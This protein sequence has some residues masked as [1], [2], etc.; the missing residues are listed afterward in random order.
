MDKIELLKEWTKICPYKIQSYQDGTFAELAYDP[1]ATYDDP[2]ECCKQLTA[3][4]I[5][6]RSDEVRGLQTALDAKR[7]KFEFLLSQEKGAK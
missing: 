2:I 5:R 7:N 4:W 1:D 3:E 6:E